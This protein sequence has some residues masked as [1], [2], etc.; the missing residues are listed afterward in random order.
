MIRA[1]KPWGQHGIAQAF[2]RV[3]ESAGLSGWSVYALRHY[4]I[5]LW[6][7]AG[8][9]VHV[10][11][12][13]AGHTNLSTTQRYVHHVKTDLEEAAPSQHIGNQIGVC[14]L[15]S[16]TF[17]GGARRESCSPPTRVSPPVRCPPCEFTRAPA[18]HPGSRPGNRE[19]GPASAK[20]DPVDQ[21]RVWKPLS[22]FTFGEVFEFATLRKLSGHADPS[23]C[24]YRWRCPTP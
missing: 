11:Q 3:M 20:W 24:Y 15:R 9:P 12:R 21:S 1:G 17:D 5:T 6:L 4:A 2:N 23:R 22:P 13:M 10:V 14:G 18:E 16:T 7:R 19:R 8:I